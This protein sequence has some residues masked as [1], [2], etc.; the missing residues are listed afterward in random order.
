VSTTGAI[1]EVG[2]E[3]CLVRR[4]WN[5]SHSSILPRVFNSII[6][7]NIRSIHCRVTIVH[8]CIPNCWRIKIHRKDSLAVIKPIAM[9]KKLRPCWILLIWLLEPA[10]LSAIL[11]CP[12]SACITSVNCCIGKRFGIVVFDMNPF[13]SCECRKCCIVILRSG[14][15]PH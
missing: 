11:P 2:E 10:E 12:L 8:M 3:L 13:F 9:L 4:I 6:K 1:D 14:V 7:H 5:A 15:I